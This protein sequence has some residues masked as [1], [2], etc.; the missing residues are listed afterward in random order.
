[1]RVIAFYTKNTPYEQEVMNLVESCKKFDIP[2]TLKGYENR[3]AWVHNC[4]IKPEFVYEMLD[5]YPGERLLYL[6]ADALIRGNP[7]LI[8]TIEA[9]VAAH[10]MQ[11]GTLLSGTVLFVS[12]PAVKELVECWIREQKSR[13]DTWDQQTL[14]ETIVNHGPRLGVKFAELP[15]TYTKI[16]D[17]KWGEPVIEHMQKSREYRSQVNTSQLE[18]VPAHIFGQRIRIWDDGSFTIPRKNVNAETWLDARF[19]RTKNELRWKKQMTK[20]LAIESLR[21]F[22]T[23]QKCYI[24]GK[25]PS[26][27]RITDDCFADESAPIIC[28][29][30]SIRKI[31]SLDLENPLF[32]IQQDMSLRNTCLPKKETTKILVSEH[33]QHWYAESVN[34]YVYNAVQLGVQSSQ[35]TAICAIEIA[36]MLGATSVDMCCFDACVTKEIAYAKCVGY[37]PTKGG[38]PERF[39]THRRHIDKHLTMKHNWIIPK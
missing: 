27:D 29:N 2:I 1:M 34:R 39:L 3:G 7:S 6:D 33:A 9:D 14:H 25:G 36:K 20:S 22:F 38:K 28:C 30:E 13:P 12:N 26:L 8:D 16:F 21:P 11:G 37:S 35:L 17:K 10:I 32:M 18:G 31:E 4:A 19:Q 23:G 24:V 15:A 5:K